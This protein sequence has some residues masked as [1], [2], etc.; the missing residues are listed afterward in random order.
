MTAITLQQVLKYLGRYGTAVHCEMYGNYRYWYSGCESAVKFFYERGCVIVMNEWEY[1]GRK[2]LH[3]NVHQTAPDADIEAVT[4]AWRSKIRE[5]AQKYENP[6]FWLM[7]YILSNGNLPPEKDRFDGWRN[8][9]RQGEKL[10]PD[11]RVRALTQE[12]SQAL[13]TACAP[14]LENDTRYGKQEAETFLHCDFDPD[15]KSRLFGIFDGETLIGTATCS[16][17]KDLHLACLN[18]VFVAPDHRKKG[19]GKALVRTVL[20]DYSE[21]KWCYQAARDNTPSIALARSL[22]FTLEGAGLQVL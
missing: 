16:Y 2:H 15:G 19:W 20:S 12:D 3:C 6:R 8:F 14:S 11:N 21:S 22:G 17:E 1:E 5:R 13:K 7:M 10:T 9:S 18:D 4:A